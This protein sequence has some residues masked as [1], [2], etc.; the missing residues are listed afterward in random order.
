MQGRGPRCFLCRK[1]RWELSEYL[2]EPDSFLL[3]HR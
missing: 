3:A 1:E 2:K